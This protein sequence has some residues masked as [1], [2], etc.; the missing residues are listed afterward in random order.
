MLIQT[1]FRQYLAK[2]RVGVMRD[3]KQ[4]ATTIQAVYRGFKARQHVRR[5]R[6]ATAYH[7]SCCNSISISI[8]SSSSS[9]SS[10]LVAIVV[11]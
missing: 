4:A 10:R 7:R 6:Y 8:S 1:K 3:Q 9:S 11:A 5:I 2:T